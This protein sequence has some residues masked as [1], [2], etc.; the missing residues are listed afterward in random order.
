MRTSLGAAVALVLGFAVAQ[1]TGLRWLGGV[2][3]VAAAAWCGLR[4]WRAAG[5]VRAALAV[6]VFG[7]GFVVSHPLGHL[8]GAWPSVLLTAVV[9]GVIAWFLTP[10]RRPGT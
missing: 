3:L 9:C 7:A 1:G 10:D 2:V 6:L 5:P 8:I 4:W